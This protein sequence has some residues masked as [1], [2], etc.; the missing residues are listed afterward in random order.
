MHFF[1]TFL[2][3]ALTCPVPAFATIAALVAGDVSTG[4]TATATVVATAVI[5]SVLPAPTASIATVAVAV[6]TTRATAAPTLVVA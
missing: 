1:V 4:P 6:V 3:P 5:A 2:L